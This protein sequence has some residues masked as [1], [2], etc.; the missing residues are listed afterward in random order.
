MDSVAWNFFALIYEHN[1]ALKG[2]TPMHV[3]AWVES[4][5]RDEYEVA[6]IKQ[7]L[8]AVRMLFD[9]LGPSS[10]IPRCS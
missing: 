5:K 7:H 9:Y 8:A 10:V 3:A 6:T 2:I 4:L 1:V